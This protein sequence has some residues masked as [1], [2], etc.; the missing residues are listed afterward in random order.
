MSQSGNIDMVEQIHD[1]KWVDYFLVFLLVF[2]SGNPIVSHLTDW[3]F[4]YVGLSLFVYALVLNKVLGNR[5][6]LL[7][8]LSMVV[9]NIMQAYTLNKVSFNANVNYLFKIYCG[10]IVVSILGE[11]FRGVY[12]KVISTL[13]GISILGFMANIFIGEF[14]GYQFDRY[15]SL[16]FYNY[17]LGGSDSHF[18]DIGTRNSGMFWEPGAFQGY[19]NIAFLLYIDKFNV[20]FREYKK[21][22]IILLLALLST[23][24]TTGYLVFFAIIV[25]S[26][27]RNT[28]NIIAKV[29][30]TTFVSI[31]A[32]W[33]YNNL[34]FMGEKINHEYEN[35]QEINNRG[36]ASSRMGSA[37]ISWQNLMNNPLCGNGHLIEMRYYGIS[38]ADFNGGGNGFFGAMNMFG[39]PMMLLYLLLLYKNYKSVPFL[40]L[41]FVVVVVIMLQGEYFLNF[42]LFWSLIFV[43][44]PETDIEHETDCNFND[45][46]QS[47]RNDIAVL[48]TGGRAA[49]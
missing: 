2:I 40:K 29:F 11:K 17:V 38:Y 3:A 19:I 10:F 16:V 36:V 30:I 33:A 1:V 5:R 26:A 22:F 13:C 46:I 45:S 15:C 34:D 6:L 43:I 12:L 9:I 49:V 18:M 7:V 42:S 37:I 41:V 8:V 39:I 48:A 44:Y 47:S 31:A 35:V 4:V 20:F 21:Y 25:L 24:S 23:F 28:K 27:F 32:F 14:P